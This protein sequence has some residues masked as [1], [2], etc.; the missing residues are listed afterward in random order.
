VYEVA[1]KENSLPGTTVAKVK[2]LD[3]DS[4]LFGSEGIRYTSLTGSIANE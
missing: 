3:K 1:L 2:A 4:G